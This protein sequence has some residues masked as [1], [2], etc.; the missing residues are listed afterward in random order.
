MD[1]H[2]WLLNIIFGYIFWG[3]TSE[4]NILVIPFKM[5]FIR[6]LLIIKGLLKFTILKYNIT[7]YRVYNFT[8]RR[9]TKQ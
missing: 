6:V 8:L 7:F 3:Y 1:N 2:I 4:V 5:Y 9:D